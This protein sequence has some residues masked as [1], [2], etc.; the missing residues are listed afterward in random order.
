[1]EP[2]VDTNILAEL[3]RPRPNE[4]V[5]RWASA[6][7][8]VAVS[9]VTI[10]EI[11][12]GLARRATPKLRSWFERFVSRDCRILDV[13]MPIAR[14]AGTLRGHLGARGQ[15]RTQADMLIAATA[16]HHGLLFVTRNGRDFEGCGVSLLNP[17]S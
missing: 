3:A 12:Y 15:T 8:L 14:L 4:G 16:A 11:Q 17:F 7:G 5:L 9:V 10:E 13:T 6:T 1:M 2:L